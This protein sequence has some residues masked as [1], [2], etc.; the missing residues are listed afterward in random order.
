MIMDVNIWYW[1]G[2]IKSLSMIGRG[3]L[4]WVG[5]RRS[6]GILEEGIKEI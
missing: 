2:G 3:K 4:N 1:K 5:S 6:W